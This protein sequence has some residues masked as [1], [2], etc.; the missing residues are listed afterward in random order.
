MRSFTIVVVL[1][2]A[3][4][5][6]SAQSADPRGKCQ[7]ELDKTQKSGS[8]LFTNDV[9]AVATGRLSEKELAKTPEGQLCLQA[10]AADPTYG[11]E[12]A[13]SASTRSADAI[14]E[15]VKAD[16]EQAALAIAKNE[17]HV[18]LAYAAMWVIAAGFVVFLWRRQQKLQLEIAQLRRDL[19]TAAK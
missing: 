16:H 2:L 3:V 15:K 10:L 14:A 13:A 18:I 9:G 5:S 11:S 8:W 1:A 6:A 17:K 7:A 4:G 19:D 12:V